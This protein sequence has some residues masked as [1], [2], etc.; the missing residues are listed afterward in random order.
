MKGFDFSESFRSFPQN[1]NRKI[2]SKIFTE[3]N[4]LKIPHFRYKK[5]AHFVIFSLKKKRFLSKEDYKNKKIK[6]RNLEI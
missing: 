4:L 2:N 5:F 6:F 3:K 1:F